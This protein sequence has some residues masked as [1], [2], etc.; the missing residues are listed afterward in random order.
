MVLHFLYQVLISHIYLTPKQILRCQLIMLE[1]D[2][3]QQLLSKNFYF[4]TLLFSKG[5][6]YLLKNNC[7][8]LDQKYIYN[9]KIINY[10]I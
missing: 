8:W 7:V 6:K 4:L 9:F 1:Y 5:I 2:H 10:L 3:H